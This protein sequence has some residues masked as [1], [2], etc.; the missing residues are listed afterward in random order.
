VGFRSA[1][2]SHVATLGSPEARQIVDQVRPEI[3]DDGPLK[4]A[5][6][7]RFPNPDPSVKAP[8]TRTTFVTAPL[9][10]DVNATSATVRKQNKLF[11]GN[12]LV[13]YMGRYLLFMCP[14]R[15]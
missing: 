1:R 2:N 5:W 12:F 11:I 4:D 10:T 8:C 13:S 14:C 6:K 15:R 7:K 9:A 3:V